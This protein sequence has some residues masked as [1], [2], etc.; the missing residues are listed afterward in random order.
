M[1]LDPQFKVYMG[2]DKFENED[3]IKHGWPEDIWFHVDKL[4]SAHVYLRL[5]DGFTIDTI[6]EEVLEDMLQLTKQNSIEGCKQNDVPIVYTPWDNLKKTGDM[7]TGQVSFFSSKRVKRKVVKTKV[8]AILNR[9]E[10]TK[11]VNDGVNL[12]EERTQRDIRVNRE[13][14]KARKERER[15]E[16][17]EQERRAKEKEA[18]S[19]DKLMD[20]TRMQTNECEEDI[21]EWEDEFM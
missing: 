18:R 16:K 7:A 17:E 12:R 2:R 19:Y 3:L 11:L 13:E 14:M 10:K 1:R 6:P 20:V 4:S 21:P 5:P 8:N 15:Q 9:L